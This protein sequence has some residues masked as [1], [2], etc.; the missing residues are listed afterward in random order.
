MSE[1][2]G[3]ALQSVVERVNQAAARRP[4]VTAVGE[5]SV[6]EHRCR[7]TTVQV[8][9][10]VLRQYGSLCKA[11]EYLNLCIGDSRACGSTFIT[12]WYTEWWYAE[13]WYAVGLYADSRVMVHNVTVSA[14]TR[15]KRNPVHNHDLMIGM[16][17]DESVAQ[18]CSRP[19]SA[20]TLQL[21]ERGPLMKMSF[22]SSHLCEGMKQ[23][24]FTVEILSVSC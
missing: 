20:H 24:I 22:S 7:V 5:A 4:K 13:W 18:P 14:C 16:F 6:W 9:H 15:S 8:Q 17:L 12:P 23:C 3:K 11:A 1:E 10:V 2:V 19:S 21:W